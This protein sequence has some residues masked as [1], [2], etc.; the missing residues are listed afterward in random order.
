MATSSADDIYADILA[1]MEGEHEE[2]R[3]HVHV[4]G[5]E[6]KGYARS[7]APVYAGPPDANVVPGAFRDSIVF[8]DAPDHEGMPAGRL[9]SRSPIAHLLE[10]GTV[11][12]HEFGTFAATAA[13]FGG[14][15]PDDTG[16]DGGGVAIGVP[17]T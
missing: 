6:M 10:F 7:I 4:E 3:E 2:I 15:G 8:E 11:H 13:A 9:I 16:T 17:A 5:D 14:E 12:M 1:G